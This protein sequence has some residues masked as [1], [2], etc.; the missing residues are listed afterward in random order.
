[1]QVDVHLEGRSYP[2]VIAAGA[3]QD[4]RLQQLVKGRAVVIVSDQTVGA[5]YLA[6][7]AQRLSPFAS[8]VIPVV[9]ALSEANKKLEYIESIVGEMLQARCDRK[10]VMIALGGGVVGD[11]AGF[12][13]AIYQ[14]GID[15]VQIPTTLLAMVD[16][17]VGGKT[18]VNHA[19]GKNMMGAFYQPQ[20]VLADLDFLQT[21]PARE[22]SAGLAEIIKHGAIAD[23]TYL[24]QVTHQMA[25]LLALDAEALGPVIARSCEIKAA[26]VSA[27][28][29]E[30]GLR[31]H[32]NFGHTFGHAIEAGLGYG[33]WL[34]GEAVGAGMVMAADLSARLGLI[35]GA[36]QDVVIKAIAAARLPLVG[37][38][39]GFDKYTELMSTDKKASAG[40]PK[41]IL[42]DGLG[43]AVIRRV[44]DAPLRQTIEACT[45]SAQ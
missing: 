11:M 39:W 34:H 45:T 32:L 21:L 4:P 38:A 7:L 1:M 31:A 13:A 37:P 42:L 20:M 27:D 5:L 14:R 12:A 44:E 36:Q 33:Q 23:A 2:I 28:E 17:S 9:M 43:S 29:L 41:F 25:R 15:F 35:T 30:Q 8:I 19:L 3:S 10:T 26:V 24:T 6:Q 18:G 40:T 16:S 22:V